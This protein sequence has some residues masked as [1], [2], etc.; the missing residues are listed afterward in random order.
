MTKMMSCA[1]SVGI[2]R[3]GIIAINV[4]E[5]AAIPPNKN[6]FIVPPQIDTYQTT[7]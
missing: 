3:A 1:T 5:S 7:A 4:R 2:D 6:L